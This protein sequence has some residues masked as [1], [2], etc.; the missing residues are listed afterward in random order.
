[1]ASVLPS[2]SATV[3]LLPDQNPISLGIPGGF[4]ADSQIIVGIFLINPEH[5]NHHITYGHNEGEGNIYTAIV[6]YLTFFYLKY[7][8]GPLKIVAGM[9]A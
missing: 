9:K 6:G 3:G 2:H 1:M 5:E 8:A 7:I 4:T